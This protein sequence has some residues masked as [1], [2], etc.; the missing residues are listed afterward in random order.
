MMIINILE[1][2]QNMLPLSKRDETKAETPKQSINSVFPDPLK[3]FFTSKEIKGLNP[4]KRISQPV[5]A[6][7]SSRIPLAQQHGKN[8]VDDKVMSTR[9]SQD[10]RDMSLPQD[11]FFEKSKKKKAE[12]DALKIPKSTLDLDEDIDNIRHHHWR[13]QIKPKTQEKQSGKRY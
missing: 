12:E 2:P 7:T 5:V 8:L 13:D 6:T 10:H 4:N 1:P 11:F 9:H 3:L